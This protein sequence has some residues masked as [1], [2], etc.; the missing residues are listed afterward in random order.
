MSNAKQI[1]T[2]KEVNYG[3]EGKKSRGKKT[4][5]F[6]EY[7]IWIDF[8]VNAAILTYIVMRITQAFQT[9][10]DAA[11]AKLDTGVNIT[12]ISDLDEVLTGFL[13]TFAVTIAVAVVIEIIYLVLKLCGKRTFI[14]EKFAV[15]F[16]IAK[17]IS[18]VFMSATALLFL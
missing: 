13:P 4:K 5:S 1:T 2:M 18:V 3:G 12:G 15:I 8:P 17:V 16:L 14:T 9:G 11:L 10:I 7:A 6:M